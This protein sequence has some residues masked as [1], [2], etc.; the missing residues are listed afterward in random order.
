MKLDIWASEDGDNTNL[1]VEAVLKTMD[2]A[3]QE[4][5]GSCGIPPLL[6]LLRTLPL[7]AE[8]C[9]TQGA[10]GAWAWSGATG[11]WCGRNAGTGS[12]DGC[13]APCHPGTVR[14]GTASKSQ[15]NTLQQ[16]LLGS[17]SNHLNPRPGHLFQPWLQAI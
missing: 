4:G 16:E 9:C 7:T 17:P 2:R 12:H 13:L 6:L 15:H 11:H 14:Q 3:A 1:C 8:D 10:A 5:R